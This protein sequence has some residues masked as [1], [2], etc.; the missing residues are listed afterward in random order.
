MKTFF[1]NKVLV[2]GADHHNTLAIVRCLGANGCDIKVL[3]HGKVDC[4]EESKVSHSRYARGKVES[5]TENS[6]EIIEWLLRNEPVGK[7][8]I[9]FPCSDFAAMVVDSAG[10]LWSRNFIMHGFRG[11][12][13]KTTI[14]MDKFEQ[15]KFA[16]KYGFPMAYTWTIACGVDD[17]PE[18][19]IYPCIVKPKLSAM[20]IKSDIRIC[21]TKALLE[22]TLKSFAAKGYSEVIV[23]QFLRKLYEECAYGCIIEAEPCFCGGIVKKIR[24][25]PP[26][27]GSTSYARFIGEQAFQTSLA[28]EILRVLY[29]EGYR[30]MFDIEL[31]VCD[32]K[33][34]LNEIN[35]RHS[36][37]GYALLSNKVPA[38][39]YYCID[40]LG[41]SLPSRAKTVVSK[42]TYHMDEISDIVHLIK[43]RIS[44]WEWLK[45]VIQTKAFAK[46]C[47]KDISGSVVWFAP[48]VKRICKKLLK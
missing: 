48:L 13:G 38:P 16:D 5:C 12:P 26:E 8:A 44:V 23:Q 42:C 18:D 29:D 1:E 41:M 2:I 43:R 47:L 35:F 30:G 45:C 34:Y 22:E 40:A 31:F 14:L 37:N 10:E 4:N 9:V 6:Q 27:G 46:I 24:E 19:M 21:E 11:T 39:L 33:V 7:P 17:I 28:M 3:I 15:K 32:D 20:G 25:N 36:G